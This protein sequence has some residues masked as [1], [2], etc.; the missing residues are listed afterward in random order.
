MLLLRSDAL[1]T[2]HTVFFQIRIRYFLASS[3]GSLHPT[4]LAVSL[5][6]LKSLKLFEPLFA[7]AMQM[8]PIHPVAAP[9]VHHCATY[10][11][12]RAQNDWGDARLVKS[13]AE[14]QSRQH[15]V[16]PKQ[17]KASRRLESVEAHADPDDKQD[18][19]QL[20]EQELVSWV[21]CAPDHGDA[22]HCTQ[23]QSQ[24]LP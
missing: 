22:S 20:K 11:Y 13:Q 16:A 2:V 9:H 8:Q 24:V 7:Q 21:V 19:D 4:E 5:L 3:I 15:A 10:Q 12:Q 1:H 23:D 17:P 14:D 6:C 18:V